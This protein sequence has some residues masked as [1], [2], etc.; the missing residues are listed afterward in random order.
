MGTPALYVGPQNY[1]KKEGWAVMRKVKGVRV[2]LKKIT[3]IGQKSKK[4][5]EGVSKWFFPKFISE[6][7]EIQLQRLTVGDYYHLEYVSIDEHFCQN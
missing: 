6:F 4:S 1:T 2:K 5:Q 3:S 7:E